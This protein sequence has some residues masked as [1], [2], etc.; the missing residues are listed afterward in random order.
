MS[1]FRAF[2][3]QSRYLY[4]LRIDPGLEGVRLVLAVAGDVEPVPAPA[5][6]VMG[7]GEQA[8]DDLRER[9]GRLVDRRTPRPPRA[10]AAGRSG[11]TWPGGSR[12][13]CRP[14]R[15]AGAPSPRAG[16]RTKRSIAPFGHEASLTA[17]IG[18]FSTGRNAQN[19][20]SSGEIFPDATTLGRADLGGRLGPDG[21]VADPFARAATS[22]SLSFPL[23]GIWRSAE[24][25]T[26][27]IRRLA[28]GRP[29][30]IAGPE[31][32]PLIR[33]ARES[34]RRPAFCL[35]GPW[36]LMQWASRTGR[37]FPSKNSTRAGSGLLDRGVVGQGCGEGRPERESNDEDDRPAHGGVRS[38]PF[39]SG[40]R[41]CGRV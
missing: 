5:L 33:A 41:K 10:S 35:L 15:R 20:R 22:A 36:Q 29:G 30:S 24:W 3:T 34:S 26:A 19:A 9:V 2:T 21:A 4:P 32:P 38:F 39:I 25:F 1:A 16:S 23:G 17:G 11:R 37:T 31:S 27:S 14:G 40:E 13:A 12:I 7:V 28:S 6:A 18:G 8:V